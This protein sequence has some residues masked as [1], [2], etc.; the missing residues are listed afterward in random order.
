MRPT[1]IVLALLISFTVSA[2][3]Y[4]PSSIVLNN[5]NELKIFC[6]L[7]NT[8]GMGYDLD[9]EY[10]ETTPSTE[11]LYSILEAKTQDE[12]NDYINSCDMPEE[13]EFMDIRLYEQLEQFLYSTQIYDI[14]ENSLQSFCPAMAAKISTLFPSLGMG[15]IYPHG[16][17]MTNRHLFFVKEFN[18]DGGA[19]LLFTQ[20]Y[21]D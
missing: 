9:I 18:R 8:A 15:L 5:L 13:R 2:K 6:Q 17:E 4:Q 7:C 20:Y 14:S 19:L 3:K 21:N 12:I 11:E 10:V 16:Y 1:L